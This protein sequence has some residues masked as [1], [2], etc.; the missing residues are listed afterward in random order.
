VPLG[1]WVVRE[2]VRN[3]FDNPYESFPTLEQA[4][5]HVNSK[6]RLPVDRYRKQSR[7]LQQKRLD[8]F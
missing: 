7:I 6:L 2:T 1:V 4:L 3:A 8:S 5:D